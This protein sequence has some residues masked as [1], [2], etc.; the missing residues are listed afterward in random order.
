MHVDIC[1]AKQPYIHLHSQ[2]SMLVPMDKDAPV[3][4][5]VEPEEETI[6]RALG[7][8]ISRLARAVD[9][10]RSVSGTAASSIDWS[11]SA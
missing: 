1:L 10:D 11:L 7:R 4:G 2:A 3:P 6:L 9:I 8:V 5:A